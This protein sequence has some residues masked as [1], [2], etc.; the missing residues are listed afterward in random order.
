MLGIRGVLPLVC[1]DH[2]IP[3]IPVDS[4]FMHLSRSAAFRVGPYW[5]IALQMRRK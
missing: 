5:D 4:L 3:C 2:A 1:T